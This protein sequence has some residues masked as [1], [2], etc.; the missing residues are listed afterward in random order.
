MVL[1][2]NV[3]SS[4]HPI[5]AMQLQQPGFDNR[6]S[7]MQPFPAWSAIEEVKKT[8]ASASQKAQKTTGKIEPWSAEY[9]A[10]CIVGGLLACVSN[11]PF[12][13]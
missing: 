1:L 4:H 11:R 5:G 7:S 3:F 6:K 10:A 13:V 9:Y 2:S 8:A 12:M